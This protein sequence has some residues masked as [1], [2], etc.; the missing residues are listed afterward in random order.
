MALRLSSSKCRVALTTG[1]EGNSKV[2]HMFCES[3]LYGV[4]CKLDGKPGKK[5]Y[6]L[7]NDCFQQVDPRRG[8][9]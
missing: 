6:V 8:K 1:N 9:A 3:K 7:C 4:R 5:A 2:S